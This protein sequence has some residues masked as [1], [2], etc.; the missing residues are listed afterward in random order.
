M[1]IPDQAVARHA[2]QSIGYYRL[3]GYWCL[4]RDPLS[5]DIGIFRPDTHF[6]QALALYEFDHQLKLLVLDAIARVEVTVRN[7]IGEHVALAHGPFAHTDP[8]RF[9]PKFNHRHWLDRLREETERAKD[10]FVQ[11][12]KTT[13]TNYPDLPIWMVTEVMSFGALSR[14]YKGLHN[15]DKRHVA[16]YFNM[17]HKRL[18]D[19][20]HTLTYIRNVCA[21]HSRLWN[22]ELAIR[23]EAVR[24]AEWNPPYTPSNSRVFYILLMLR[25][26]LKASNQHR[27]WTDNATRLLEPIAESDLYRTS[28]GMPEAWSA[29]PLWT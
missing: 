17:H 7:Q 3:S 25:C 21:H 14:F 12:F 22:R 18:A 6:D 29:H 2:L 20:L 10:D 24:E 26:L 13:Y 5:R 28:M 1:S 4:F 8:S 19:W 9:H 16:A 23:A 11:H 15:D 27:A